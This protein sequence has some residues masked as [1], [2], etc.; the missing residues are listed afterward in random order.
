MVDFYEVKWLSFRIFYELCGYKD[1]STLVQE[2]GCKL[3]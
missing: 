1:I 2:Q 3:Q